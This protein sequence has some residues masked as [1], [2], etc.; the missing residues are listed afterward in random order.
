M[1]LTRTIGILFIFFALLAGVA[2][3]SGNGN[4][5][6]NRLQEEWVNEVRD[7]IDS[8]GVIVDQITHMQWKEGPDQPTNWYDAQKWIR[9]L[10]DGW[11]FPTIE[12]LEK[13]YVKSSK[14]IGGEEVVSGKPFGP[15]QL[16]LD[17]AFKLHY[18]Y[19][20]WS[21]PHSEYKS[22]SWMFNFVKGESL[23]FNN[24]A[25][26]FDADNNRVNTYWAT[27]AFAVRSQN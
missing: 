4:A 9:S 6:L 1:K 17:P 24:D 7:R 23:H 26:W 5:K 22:S 25:M 18:S 3:A 12:E 21:V 20:V 19:N 15:Y 10:G 8:N 2:H 16:K 14:R 11:R 13:L 27:R